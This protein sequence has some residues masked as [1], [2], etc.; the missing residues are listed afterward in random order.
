MLHPDT[1]AAVPTTPGKAAWVL[2]GVGLTLAAAEAGG[3]VDPALPQAVA[4]SA[5]PRPASA[6]VRRRR[7]LRPAA[8]PRLVMRP[9]IC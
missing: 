8:H 6:G 9:I 1:A 4:A 5:N 3:M 2:V 7:Q